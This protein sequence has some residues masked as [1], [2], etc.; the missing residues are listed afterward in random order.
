MHVSGGDAA[1][2][3]LLMVHSSPFPQQACTQVLLVGQ[4]CLGV[5]LVSVGGRGG[6]AAFSTGRV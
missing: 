6:V 3:A 5:G 1:P 2:H 4:G